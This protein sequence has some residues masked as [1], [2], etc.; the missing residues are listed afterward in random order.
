M[1]GPAGC[2]YKP[3]EVFDIADREG[4]DYEAKVTSNCTEISKSS[5]SLHS[6]PNSVLYMLVLGWITKLWHRHITLPWNNSIGLT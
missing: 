6:S 3:E 4:I 2:C 5:S 1:Y